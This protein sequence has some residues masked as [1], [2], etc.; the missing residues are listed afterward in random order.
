MSTQKPVLY[1]AEDHCYVFE[2]PHCEVLT[3]VAENE[4]NCQI[5]RHGTLKRTGIQVN[6]HA[7]KAHCAR[8]IKQDLVHGCCLPFKLF[9]GGFGGIEYADKCEYI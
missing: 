4:V 7:S 9:R 1:I 5:F 6:P 8:L 2:C 3:Q